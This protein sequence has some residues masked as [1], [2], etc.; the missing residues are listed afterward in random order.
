M[1]GLPREFTDKELKTYDRY[2]DIL[3]EIDLDY[4]N[5]LLHSKILVDRLCYLT[6]FLLPDFGL[7]E[8]FSQHRDRILKGFEGQ[9]SSS[10]YIRYVREN[11]G[12]FS[13]LLKP[14]RDKLVVHARPF[15]SGFGGMLV[16]K[17]QVQI[18][19]INVDSTD[20]AKHFRAINEIKS[21]YPESERLQEE[22]NIHE[23]IEI[24]LNMP[25]RVSD[26]KRVLDIVEKLGARFPP[27]GSICAGIIGYAEVL[28][29]AGTREKSST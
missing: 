6:R 27:L 1:T 7:P 9:P 2:Q 24:L 16:N 10:T 8:R 17:G 4:H 19:R 22:T 21:N 11:T 26:E 29:S 3:E 25:L 18:L 5:F 28:T 12:W 13:L 20:V 14:A 15:P 23:I